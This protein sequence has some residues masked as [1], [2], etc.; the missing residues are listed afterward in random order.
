MCKLYIRHHHTLV[1]TPLTLAAGLRC[2]VLFVTNRPC[3]FGQTS[4]AGAESA[5]ECV[6]ESQKCPIGQIAPPDAVSPEQCGCLPGY[7]GESAVPSGAKTQLQG[8][9]KVPHDI[10]CMFA[11]V[12]CSQHPWGEPDNLTLV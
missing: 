9:Y 2:N 6:P 3:P 7:G 8:F 11:A 10:S 1:S 4:R 5:K 12:Q